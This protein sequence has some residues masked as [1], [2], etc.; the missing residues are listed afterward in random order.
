MEHRATT[1]LIVIIA[2]NPQGRSCKF[3]E[4]RFA[5]CALRFALDLTD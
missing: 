1:I 4:Q 5:L 2:T 3:K